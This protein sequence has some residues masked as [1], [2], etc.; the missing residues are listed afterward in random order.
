MAAATRLAGVRVLLRR[1][2]AGE[3]PREGRDVEVAVVMA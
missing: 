1:A 2:S 3:M